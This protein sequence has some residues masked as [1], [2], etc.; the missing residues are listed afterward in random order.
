MKTLK[1]K[2][3]IRNFCFTYFLKHLLFD[4]L[5]DDLKSNNF[6]FRVHLPPSWLKEFLCLVISKIYDSGKK[7]SVFDL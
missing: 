1:K 4:Y 6:Y 2:I 3:Q 7:H 5:I